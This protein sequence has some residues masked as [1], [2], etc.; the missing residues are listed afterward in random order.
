MTRRLRI[1]VSVF[2]AVLT[3]ALC[4]Q[5]VRSY[6]WQD[7]IYFWP[8][9]TR[10]ICSISG[11]GWLQ[12]DYASFDPITAAEQSSPW[13]ATT[14][15]LRSPTASPRPGWDWGSHRD[16]NVWD[17]FATFPYWFALAIT[18]IA[19]ALPWYPYSSRFSLRA[20]LLAVTLVAVVLGL[21]IWLIS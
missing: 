8:S 17:T 14:V 15:R 10:L 1:A 19:G 9:R 21:G 16:I 3:V 13:E 5:W 2:F 11:H 6:W 12:I 4:V 18:G 20:M 7:Y